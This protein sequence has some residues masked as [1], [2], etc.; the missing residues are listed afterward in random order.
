[1][2]FFQCNY[3]IQEITFQ[4]TIAHPPWP[5]SFSKVSQVG[6]EAITIVRWYSTGAFITGIELGLYTLRRIFCTSL[7]SLI[8]QFFWISIISLKVRIYLYTHILFRALSK[9]KDAHIRARV[10]LTVHAFQFN[11]ICVRWTNKTDLLVT[12]AYSIY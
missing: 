5:Y 7:C 9:T 8:K 10:S 12:L 3:P 6:P 11:C 4:L 1:M 2:K